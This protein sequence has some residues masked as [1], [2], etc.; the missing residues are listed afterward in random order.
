MK[1]Y[2]G[3]KEEDVPADPISLFERW[4]GER[5]AK[6]SVYP[7]AFS[8]ATS[9]PQG[10]ISARIVL[11]KSFDSEGFVFFT[12]YDSRKGKT[13][14]SNSRV[15]M[16]FYW[17]E[18]GRQIRIEGNAIRTSESES[19]AYFTSR[20]RESR[21][22]A[23]ASKQSNIIKNRDYLREEFDS[24]SAKF[25]G[26][27]IPRPNY[28]GGYR[29]IPGYFEFWQEGKHRL[30]DRIIFERKDHGWKKSRLSP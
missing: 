17:P 4:Y 7:D 28:W 27:S 18:S 16:L 20:P 14:K 6:V 13:I 23:W 3:L 26:R 2:K 19:D 15:A 9:S 24:Y 25:N 12:N 5:I 11:L 1:K 10:D 22:G 29:I 21:I 30:H 8:L